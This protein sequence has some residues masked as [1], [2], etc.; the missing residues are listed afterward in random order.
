MNNLNFL[1]YKDNNTC[2]INHELY[3]EN[4]LKTNKPDEYKIRCNRFTCPKCDNLVNN[5]KITKKY[6]NE[7]NKEKYSQYLI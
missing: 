2:S 3:Y 5:N 1:H 7:S 6:M 4:L